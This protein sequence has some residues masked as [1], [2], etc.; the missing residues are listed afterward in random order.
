MS[1]DSAVIES[2]KPGVR[3]K[4]HTLMKPQA[5]QRIDTKHKLLHTRSPLASLISDHDNVSRNDVSRHDRFIG[6]LIPF[7]YLRRAFDVPYFFKYGRRTDDRPL[8]RNVAP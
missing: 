4:S 3:D 5:D 8:R 1:Y 2:G 6:R 7:K